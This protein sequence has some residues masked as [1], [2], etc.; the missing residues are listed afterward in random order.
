MEKQKTEHESPLSK[1]VSNPSSTAQV[2]SAATASNELYPERIPESQGDIADQ[3]EIEIEQEI[4]AQIF[5]VRQRL[6]EQTKA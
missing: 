6:K 5:K 1:A 4:Q 3:A 2:E